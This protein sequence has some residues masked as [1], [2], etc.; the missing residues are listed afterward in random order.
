MI[1][2]MTEKRTCRD[3]GV[4]HHDCPP[5]DCFRER[6]CG[7]LPGYKGPWGDCTY[8][9]SG[10]RERLLRLLLRM[11]DHK[12]SVHLS[13]VRDEP[14]ML[15]GDAKITLRAGDMVQ[16]EVFQVNNI[17]SDFELRNDV[18]DNLRVLRLEDMFNMFE[19]FLDEVDKK[20]SG[21]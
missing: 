11:L 19:N 10:G 3:G 13:L 7:P 5:F 9:A 17:I 4:C 18:N 6:C 21:K 16:D 1:A 20:Q 2:A 8:P 14:M 12:A 15:Q